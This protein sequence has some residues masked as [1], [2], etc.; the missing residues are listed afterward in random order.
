MRKIEIMILFENGSRLLM[1]LELE[2]WIPPQ[3]RSRLSAVTGWMFLLTILLQSGRGSSTARRID[4]VE[5]LLNVCSTNHYQRSPPSPLLPDLDVD[6]G[7]GATGPKNTFRSFCGSG[8]S[9]SD[10]LTCASSLNRKL[11]SRYRRP[12]RCLGIALVGLT[13]GNNI[14]DDI[15]VKIQAEMTPMLV[16]LHLKQHLITVLLNELFFETSNPVASSIIKELPDDSFATLREA[17]KADKHAE[18][19]CHSGYRGSK[20][21]IFLILFIR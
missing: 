21:S 9:V 11:R 4:K 13:N 8:Y 18:L 7:L 17:D 3:S 6:K 16:T 1:S 19:T 12:R 5:S 10:R 2:K 15:L 14:P 20:S